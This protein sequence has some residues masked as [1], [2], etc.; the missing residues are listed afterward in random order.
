M[1]SNKNCIFY[2]LS[3]CIHC[4]R[5]LQFL[6]ENNVNFELHF[7]DQ[8]KGK[9]RED[10]LDAVRKYNSRLSFPTILIDGGKEVVVG[11]DSAALTRALGL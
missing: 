6:K 9:E 4:K 7:V 11:F 2:G 1:A 3:T 10:L 8:A 5:A